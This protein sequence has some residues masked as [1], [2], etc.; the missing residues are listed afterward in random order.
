MKSLGYI[1]DM[2]KHS[3]WMYAPIHGGL[4]S[5]DKT[6]EKLCNISQK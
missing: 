3:K 4:E 6:Y 1:T 2:S 5:E